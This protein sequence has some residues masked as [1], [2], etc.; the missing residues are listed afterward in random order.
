[1]SAQVKVPNVTENDL[2]LNENIVFLRNKKF[3]EEKEKALFEKIKK[4]RRRAKLM[5]SSHNHDL[6]I[7]V[8]RE[9]T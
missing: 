9:K 8:S 4:D 7:E 3:V 6:G 5:I 2:I 1:M